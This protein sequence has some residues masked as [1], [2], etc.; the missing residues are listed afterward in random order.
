MEKR[1][2]ALRQLRA[3]AKHYNSREFVCAITLA[4]AAEEILGKIARKSKGNN[5]LDFELQYLKEVY[6]YMSV[7]TPSDKE[8]RKDINFIKNELKHNESED[9]KWIGG[10]FENEAA[11]LFIKAVKNY[12]NSFDEFP[13]DRIIKKLFN[14]LTL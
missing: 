10:N 11:V 7:K 1:D 14:N 6:K 3:A 4:G 12:F 9:N 13:K 8:I 2:I 5:Q